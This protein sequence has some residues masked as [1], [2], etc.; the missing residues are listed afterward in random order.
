MA[1]KTIKHGNSHKRKMNK[2]IRREFRKHPGKA[3]RMRVDFADFT[4]KEGSV[5]WEKYY[6]AQDKKLIA[7][8]EKR[9]SWSRR[10]VLAGLMIIMLTVPFVSV[11]EKN[12][13]INLDKGLL[14]FDILLVIL[15]LVFFYLAMRNWDRSNDISEE[16]Y[17]WT[18]CKE[19]EEFI[20][21]RFDNDLVKVILSAI[22][23]RDTY[24]ITVKK[25]D[26]LIL[27]RDGEAILNFSR[28]GFNRITNYDTKQLSYYIAKHALT[29]GFTIYQTQSQVISSNRRPGGVTDFGG[30]PKK[31]KRLDH[32]KNVLFWLVTRIADALKIKLPGKVAQ[33]QK[34]APDPLMNSGQLIL[35]KGF[36]R[37]LPELDTL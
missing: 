15:S 8:R 3:V 11:D 35:N 21:K 14:L 17:N 18:P 25:D 10:Q 7:E 23:V 16:R 24:S 2:E 26:V 5:N 9:D 31:E 1:D 30:S 19:E 36:Q 37:V 33:F 32:T 28:C 29:E 12:N 22:S 34:H 27:N 20:E 6:L 13:S 4:D